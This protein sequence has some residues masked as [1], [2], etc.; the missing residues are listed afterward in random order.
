MSMFH[1]F[2]EFICN[3]MIQIILLC[4]TNQHSSHYLISHQL[5]IHSIDLSINISQVDSN[6]FKK[7]ERS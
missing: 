1:L 6:F 5:Y 2:I 4:I 7:N 3:K